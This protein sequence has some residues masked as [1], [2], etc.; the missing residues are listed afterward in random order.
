MQTN[1]RT[2]LH[3]LL[4]LEEAQQAKLTR[5]YDLHAVSMEQV[6]SFVEGEKTL[7]FPAPMTRVHCA[8]L[9]EKRPSV[10][11]ADRVFAWVAGGGAQQ[12][13]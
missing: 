8:N 4:Y 5:A 1:W 7:Y 9:A 6:T 3:E 12:Q 10:Q 2:R 13:P 11:R